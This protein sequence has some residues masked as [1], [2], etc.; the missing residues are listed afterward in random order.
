MAYPSYP[1]YPLPIH[2]QTEKAIQDIRCQIV[3]C[4]CACLVRTAKKR[5]MKC[6]LLAQF[7][8][9]CAKE[10]AHAHT[11]YARRC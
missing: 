7:H 4:V 2:Q 1:S 8:L 3:L 9:A 5:D 6:Q 11:S 10:T